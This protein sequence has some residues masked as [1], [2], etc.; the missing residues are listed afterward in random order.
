MMTLGRKSAVQLRRNPSVVKAYNGSL[1]DDGLV[2][3]SFIRDLLEIE[4]ILVGSAQHNAARP[5]QDMTLERLWGNHCALTY[6]NMN[7]RPNKGV[8][9]GMTAEHGQRVSS[10]RQDG[11]IGL[12]GGEVIRVGE[13]LTELVVCDDVAYF[14]EN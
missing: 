11:N 2:P 13:S 9:F 6:R 4:E 1:G 14:L 7:A 10:T 8:T 3:M 12:R 5:G